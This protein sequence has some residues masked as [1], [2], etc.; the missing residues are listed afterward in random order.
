MIKNQFKTTILLAVLTAILLFA[1]QALGG[2][3][4]LIIAV[5]L[6]LLLNFGSY[7]YSDKIILKTYKAKEVTSGR[8][9]NIVKDVASIAN[10]PM[11]KVY[12]IPSDSPN[13]FATGRNPKHS[14]V[15]ATKGIL[16]LLNDTE[17]KGVIAHEVSHIRHRDTLIQTVSGMIAGVISFVASM[18][19]WA[20]IFGGFGDDDNNI[21][22]LLVLMIV[23]PLA[24]TIVQLSIS[25]SR[26]FMADEGAAK[27]LGHGDG[28]S[29]ALL[30]LDAEIKKKPMRFG[31]DSTSHLFISNPFKKRAFS[32]LFSTHPSTQE[33]VKRLRAY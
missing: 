5:P 17:L 9:F 8:L 10:V 24:A 19:Q 7:W 3:S 21:L 27:L 11:P 31:S 18:A 6:V 1:G 33:R 22:S 12:E 23:A 30:K 25:R 20:A 2:M 29:S 15:A 4:G 28:L 13:A 26:E 32:S 14:A 16:T